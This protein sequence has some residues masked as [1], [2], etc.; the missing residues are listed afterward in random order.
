[1]PSDVVRTPGVAAVVLSGGASLGAV[2]VGMLRALLEAGVTI[3]LLVGTS[4]GAVNAAW[5]AGHPTVA[6]VAELAEV[7]SGLRRSDVFPLNPVH[8]LLAVAGHRS[9]VVS[10]SAL[11]ALLG[12][13]LTYRRLEH[14][15]LPLHVVAVDVQ[16]GDDVLLSSGP[17]VDAVLASAA[18]PGVLPCVRVGEQWLM[19]GGVV[20]N[21]PVS[22]A[23]ALGATTV[24]V[25]PAGY[26]CALAA[27]PATALAMALHGLTT[28]VEHGLALDVARYRDR[29]DLKVVPPLC[30]LAVSPADF[31]HTV[32]LLR[33]GYASTAGWLAAGCPDTSAVLA[34]HHHAPGAADQA[35]RS[36][37]PGAAGPDPAG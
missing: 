30:P 37:A 18:I 27:P 21:T 28:L 36:P 3:D 26:P 6:G 8:S 19:D 17:V 9:S 29:V 16:S 2:Q 23:V 20:N 12:H 14:A 35:G 11:R 24:W 5:V 22:H 15:A 1:M 10:D 31:T 25:L 32:E 34:P 13:Y 7:W 33:R 4:V